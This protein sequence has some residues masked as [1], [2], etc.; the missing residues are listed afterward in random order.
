MNFHLYCNKISFK[1]HLKLPVTK[2]GHLRQEFNI[3]WLILNSSGR[4]AG[5]NAMQFFR[6]AAGRKSFNLLN[7]SITWISGLG[8]KYFS[9]TSRA[10]S[11]VFL[12]VV[13]GVALYIW[14]YLSLIPT[15]RLEYNRALYRDRDKRL[16]S[17]ICIN[18][19]FQNQ[20][21]ILFEG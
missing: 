13:F 19:L 18:I 21:Y 4:E 12:G 2:N 16:I 7:I 5:H 17:L 11:D 6:K 20:K 1:L 3:M 8:T 9:S 15:Y 14:N 10:T